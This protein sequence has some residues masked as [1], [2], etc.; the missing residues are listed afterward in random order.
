MRKHYDGQGLLEYG[1]IG[2]IVSVAAIALYQIV[3]SSVVQLLNVVVAA[4]P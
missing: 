3:G 1:L 4:Y 2:S